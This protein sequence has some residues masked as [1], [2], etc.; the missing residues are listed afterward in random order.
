MASDTTRR[1]RRSPRILWVSLG[2]L[3]V[4][5]VSALVWVGVRG[6]ML[7]SELDDAVHAATEMQQQLQ[8]SDIAAARGSAATLAAHSRSAADLTGDPVWRAAEFIPYVGANLTAA[9]VVSSQ[10]DELSSAA[11]APALDLADGL[12]SIWADG[13]VDIDALAGVSS[14]LDEALVAVH[15]ARSEIGSLDSRAL[16][17]PLRTG[18]EQLDE[19]LAKA[20][21]MVE[22]ARLAAATAPA[23]LGQD[24]TRSILVMLQ[25]GA[26]LRTGEGSP[27]HSPSSGPTT[28]RWRSSTKP[29]PPT[30]PGFRL[31]SRSCRHPSPRSST[32]PSVATS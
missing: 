29:L 11:V 9:R 22:G 10:L 26:E 8:A 27:E 17:G 25:N 5:V 30:S 28:A 6:L 15:D 14:A 1:P 21:P 31:P 16:V 19:Y 4:L 12:E 2:V 7:R 24:S 23:M 32:M 13:R 18:V 3:G 20:E